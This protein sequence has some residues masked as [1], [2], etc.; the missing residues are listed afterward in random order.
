M[1]LTKTEYTPDLGESITKA[2]KNS[3]TLSKKLGLTTSFKFNGLVMYTTHPIDILEDK[4]VEWETVCKERQEAYEQ[5]DSYKEKEDSREMERISIQEE[6]DLLVPELC[7]TISNENLLKWLIEFTNKADHV[8]ITFDKEYVL[9]ELYKLG[10]EENMW[11]G[12]DG[13]WTEDHSIEYVVGQVINCINTFGI[14]H[15]MTVIFCEKILN[16]EGI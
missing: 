13:E 4:L 2:I 7:D 11:I 8:G 16:G 14:P 9:S 5:T 3:L 12:Y 15:T 10:F 1:S 6:M